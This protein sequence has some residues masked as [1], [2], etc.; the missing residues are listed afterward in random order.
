MQT[1]QRP[2]GYW[3]KRR[4]CDAIRALRVHLGDTQEQFAARLDLQRSTV[5]RYEL[6]RV[7]RGKFLARLEEVAHANAAYELAETF[8]QAME[9]EFAL[10]EK[11]RIVRIP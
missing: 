6:S 10:G 7:P 3:M 5:A 9:S 1:T 2:A 11:L 8:R 4:A